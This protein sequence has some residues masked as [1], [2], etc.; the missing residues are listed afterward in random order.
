MK[1]PHVPVSIGELI[2]KITILEIKTERI[3]DSEKLANVHR[4]L[5]ALTAVWSDLERDVVP[6]IDAP[7][8]RLKTVNEALWDIEDRIR[9]KEAAREFDDEFIELARS[10]YHTN[11]ERSDI[12]KE[13]NLAAGS[14]LIE[15]K[16]YDKY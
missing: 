5:D 9:R 14:E 8:A 12:K 10:V 1:Q 2:D 15:E 11:D 13:I 4:E 16:S 6:D 7:R 3:A